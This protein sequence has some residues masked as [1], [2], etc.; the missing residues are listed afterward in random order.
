M[1][2]GIEIEAEG[3]HE[4]L[5]I[6]SGELHEDGSL[7]NDG[8]EAVSPILVG[9]DEALE[10]HNA[11][12]NALEEQDADFSF[13]CGVHIHMD[14][15]DESFNNIFTFFRKYL[16]IEKKL[17]LLFPERAKSNFCLPVLDFDGD[18][19][20]LRRIFKSGVTDALERLSK[21]S[22]LNLKPLLTQGSI[23]FRAIPTSKTKEVFPIV[24]N[25]LEFIANN[26][27]EDVKTEY[28]ISDKD[29]LEVTAFC[30]AIMVDH[31]YEGL[32]ETY[33]KLWFPE[34]FKEVVEE[35]PTGITME[36]LE[37]YMRGM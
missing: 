27:Y 26:S 31:E 29:S 16:L 22:A 23:E 11:V 17:F 6:P 2:Y 37:A 4:A 15:R 10:W 24:I 30:D 34:C 33:L 12:I 18:T 20:N 13:R 35:V 8:I 3:V 1:N 5:V 28:N 21:Y 25:M 19:P 14:F 32:D 7:R 9:V 36:M